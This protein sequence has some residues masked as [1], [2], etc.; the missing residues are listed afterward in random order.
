MD[1]YVVLWKV[2]ATADW[3]VE[4]CMWPSRDNAETAAY[5]FRVRHPDFTVAT[6]EIEI[7]LPASDEKAA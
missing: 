7:P 4:D 5:L 3:H 1:R 2:G 6:S